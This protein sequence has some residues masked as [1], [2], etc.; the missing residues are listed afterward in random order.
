MSSAI[1]HA[2]LPHRRHIGVMRA[3]AALGAVGAMAVSSHATVAASPS[4]TITTVAGSVG[5]PAMATLVAVMPM[6]LAVA[7]THLYVT[8]ESFN[9]VRSINTGTDQLTAVAGSGPAGFSGDGGPGS[10]AQLSY[11]FGVAVDPSGNVVIAD[12]SHHHIRVTAASTGIFYG[13]AMTAGDI[14]TVAGNGTPTYAGDG[15][16]AISA[17]LDPAGVAVDAAGNIVFSDY[18]NGRVRVVAAKSGTF[19]GQAM[20][21]GDIYTIAGSGAYGFSGDGGPATAAE[22]DDPEGVAFDRAGNVVFDD[23]ANMRI[24]VVATTTGTFYG[25]AMTVGDIYTVA[26]NGVSG[27]AGDG[28][29]AT[30]AEFQ[31]LWQLSVDA[32]GNLIIADGTNGSVIGNDRVRSCRRHHRYVLRDVDD[33]RPHIFG[34]WRRRRRVC[35]RR[36]S[37]NGGRAQPRR[38]QRRV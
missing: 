1:C 13:Q 36:R 38:R 37:R 8:D 10:T 28:G 4:G 5:G 21:A 31:Y 2:G 14:Y 3:A 18:F 22:I 29:L 12:L 15:S 6:G 24:R 16:P 23:F 20:T 32:S 9:A 11:P 34:G 35:R 26:G 33:L 19:Y 25:R 30:S 27:Y 7:G 17:G